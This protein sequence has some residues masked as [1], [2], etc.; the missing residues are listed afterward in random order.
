MN[1]VLNIGNTF[2]KYHSQHCSKF[3]SLWKIRYLLQLNVQQIKKTTKTVKLLI[4]RINEIPVEKKM[5]LQN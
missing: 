3:L 2:E 4:E 5:A 1:L